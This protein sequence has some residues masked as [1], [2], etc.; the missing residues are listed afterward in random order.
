MRV[1]RNDAEPRVGGILLHDAPE[2]HLRRARHGV[3]LVED[4]ELVARDAGDGR[5]R[6]GPLGRGAQREDLLRRR[7]RL[8]LLAHHVDAA[9]V[10]R[11]QLQHHL[12]H[13][14]GPVDASRQ[15]ED[16]R[17][18]ACAWRAVEEEMGESLCVVCCVSPLSR[19]QRDEDGHG[20][21]KLNERSYVGVYEFVD[22][23]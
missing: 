18:L 8:D 3:G 16:R 22:C 14:L 17:R 10:R 13:V 2:R 23:G 21:G 15:R 5:R 11:V 9:V 7:K 1:I 6:R 12:S 4:D 20:D 19:S